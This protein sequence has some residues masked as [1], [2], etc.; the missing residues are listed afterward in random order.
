MRI[1]KFPRGTSSKFTFLKRED[2][3]VTVEALLWLLLYFPA[4]MLIIDVS[5]IFNGQ[6]LA[7][8]NVQDANRQASIGRLSTTSEVETYIQTNIASFAPRAVA[9]ATLSGGQI[10]STVR[11]PVGDLLMTGWF[12]ELANFD[13]VVSGSHVME[14]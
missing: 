9:T 1:L 2:G 7:Y 14:F 8:K 6:N 10:N 11:I 3:A 13:V 12:D 5:M 4:V